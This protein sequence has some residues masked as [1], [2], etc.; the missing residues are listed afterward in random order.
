MAVK[1]NQ[2]IFVHLWGKR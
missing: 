2:F 1:Q